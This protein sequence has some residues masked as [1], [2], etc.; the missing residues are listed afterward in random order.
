LT[1][2]YKALNSATV[3]LYKFTSCPFIFTTLSLIL[4]L[5]NF[6]YSVINGLSYFNI[7]WDNNLK[8]V[9]LVPKSLS[10]SLLLFLWVFKAI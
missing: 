5:I 2:V 8:A 3:F 7:T 10:T 4:S 9:F 6:S 1:K